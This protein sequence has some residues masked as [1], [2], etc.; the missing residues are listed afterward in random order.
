[1]NDIQMNRRGDLA[2]MHSDIG[3]TDSIEQAILIRL[4]WFLGEYLYGPEFGVD[5]FGKILIKNPNKLL[6]T[7]LINE[8][9]TA[10][11]GVREVSDLKLTLD[12]K[13]RVGTISFRVETEQGPMDLMETIDF[14]HAQD[15]MHADVDGSRLVLKFNGAFSYVRGSSAYFT[16]YSKAAVHNEKLRLEA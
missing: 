10:V 12:R 6:I 4:R 8:Q 15:V 9:I 11:D 13:T 2:I 3:V 7:G 5:Y 16:K 14:D 1:M